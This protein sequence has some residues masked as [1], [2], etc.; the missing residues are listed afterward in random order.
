MDVRR[1]LATLLGA[2][3]AAVVLAAP[4]HATFPGRNGSLVFTSNY[5]HGPGT[6]AVSVGRVSSRTGRTRTALLC[7]ASVQPD[8]VAASALTVSPEGSR[9]ALLTIGGAVPPFDARLRLVPLGPGA[10][11]VTD[12]ADPF[13][14]PLWFAPRAR[15]LRWLPGGDRLS[16]QLFSPRNE[17]LTMGLGADGALGPQLLAPGATAV[18]WADDGRAAFV[19]DGDIRVA[20]ANGRERRLTFRGADQPSWSPHGRWIAFTRGASVFAVRSAG[21][22]AR[23]LTRG[24]EPVWSP[25]GRSIAFLRRGFN[26]INDDL[27]AASFYLYSWRTKRTPRLTQPLLGESA[28]LG[29]PDWQRLPSR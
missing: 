27:A 8:C 24:S 22:P 19:R 2:S 4:A 13:R 28:A 5:N 3:A 6:T 25:D 18:D 15:G 10:P 23:R 14:Y 9:A 21:G 20:T 16:V 17:A 11:Q 26:R 7:S 12:L 1:L 29:S